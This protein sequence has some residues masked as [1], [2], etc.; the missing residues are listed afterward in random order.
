MLGH[1][2]MWRN[3]IQR[4]DVHLNTGIENILIAHGRNNLLRAKLM[5]QGNVSPRNSV[6]VAGIQ[7]ERRKTGYWLVPPLFIRSQILSGGIWENS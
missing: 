2:G 6:D 7:S 3:L 5:L 4:I 1:T